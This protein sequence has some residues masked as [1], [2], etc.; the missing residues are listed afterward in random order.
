VSAI[1]IE[2]FEKTDAIQF[3]SKDFCLSLIATLTKQKIKN[4]KIVVVEHTNYNLL[5]ILQSIIEDNI[6]ILHTDFLHHADLCY[7]NNPI[8]IST[9]VQSLIIAAEKFPTKN[10]SF[11]SEV[12]NLNRELAQVMLPNNLTI[13]YYGMGNLGFNIARYNTVPI[14]VDKQFDCYKHFLCLNNNERPH[15][16]AL[17]AYLLGTQFDQYGDIT[18]CNSTADI[19][20][21]LTWCYKLEHKDIKQKLINGFRLISKNK[22][23]TIP[24]DFTFPMKFNNKIYQTVFVEII[25][26]STFI[27]CGFINDKYVTNIHGAAFPIFVASTGTVSRLR[28]LGF[29]MFDDIIDHSYDLI[30]DHAIRLDQAIQ[31]NKHILTNGTLVKKLWQENQERFIANYHYFHNEFKLQSEKI[32]DD[33]CSIMAAGLK[34]K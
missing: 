5:E 4:Y 30:E 8:P 11:M 2:W 16:I 12:I 13:N 34:L 3:D 15:R 27:E 20:C 28:E 9:T 19:K 21:F 32:Q 6:L 22:L 14:I 1:D 31:L 26:D 18:L 33:C 29:D 23:A 24:F 25:S 7:N 10:I 17:A